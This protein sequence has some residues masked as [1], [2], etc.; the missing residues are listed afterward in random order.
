M[1]M[2]N[3]FLQMYADFVFDNMAF[4]LFQLSHHTIP[5]ENMN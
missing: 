5:V 2:G 3:A 1:D 4:D